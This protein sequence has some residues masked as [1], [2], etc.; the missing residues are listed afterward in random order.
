MGGVDRQKLEAA[1]TAKQE[2]EAK[3]SGLELRNR[4]LTMEISDLKEKVGISL[5]YRISSNTQN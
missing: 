1:L 3:M 2:T 5:L 4:E